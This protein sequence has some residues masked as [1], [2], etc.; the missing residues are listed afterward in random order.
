MSMVDT[1]KKVEQVVNKAK[2]NF[3]PKVGIVLGSGLG[4]LADEI[5]EVVSI[6]YADLPGFPVSHIVGH[7]NKLILGLL[8][9]V[10]V[11]CL[12][13]RVHMYEDP[14]FEQ[15]KMLIRSIKWLG[16]HSVVITNAAGSL[17]RE[18][19]A[20]EVCMIT[21]HINI[22]QINPLV[23]RNDDEF[24]PK[25]FPMSDAYDPELRA[26]LLEAAKSIGLKLHEGVYTASIGPNFETP[27]EIRA[28]R[29]LGVQLVGMSTVYDVLVA[30]HCSLKV[31]GISA[32][33]NLSADMS[34]VPLTHED[35]LKF[36]K[37]SGEKVIK[38]LKAFFAKY[39]K[40]LSR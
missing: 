27:A 36:A 17:R 13:G 15:V 23:G 11:M 34:D 2:P 33:T 32:V 39:S 28:F 40:E 20:G 10:P 7:G 35:T 21:D 25:F 18:V 6:P 29:T 26:K 5:K 31:V 14:P 38:L 9:G 22:T 16:C 19:P 1:L 4:P 24:G 37:I 8:E 3:K 30:R 12:S